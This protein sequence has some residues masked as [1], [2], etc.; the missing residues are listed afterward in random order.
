MAN[1]MTELY[2]ENISAHSDRIGEL[3]ASGNALPLIF[4]VDEEIHSTPVFLS[5]D[6]P[7]SISKTSLVSSI[8]KELPVILRSL[9]LYQTPQAKLAHH[10]PSLLQ[11]ERS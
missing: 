7:H 3:V 6:G 10:K 8:H 5:I 1:G 2:I 11:S 9:M 4:R